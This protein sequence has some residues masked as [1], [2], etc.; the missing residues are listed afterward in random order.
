MNVINEF[1]N[2]ETTINITFL[3]KIIIDVTKQKKIIEIIEI[4]KFDYYWD[5]SKNLNK[6]IDTTKKIEKFN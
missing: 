1:N 4:K 3:L 6:K 2:F 5:K